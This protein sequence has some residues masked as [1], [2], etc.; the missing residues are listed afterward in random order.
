MTEVLRSIGKVKTIPKTVSEEA[1][2]AD[3]ERYRRLA[4]ELGAS[5]AAIVP[6]DWV[7][8]DER[9]RL[10]CLIPRCPRVGETPNCPPNSPEPD[11][12]RKAFSHYRWA[13]AVK[14][15]V[16]SLADY[17]VK[18]GASGEQRRKAFSFHLR[19][20]EIVCQLE[21]AAYRDG[22]YLALGLG[23]GSCKDTLCRGVIC[24][25]LDSGR[26]R[27]PLRARPAMEAL[28]IDVLQLASRLGWEAYPICHEEPNPEAI[29]Y[30]I[31][32]G[33]VFIH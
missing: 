21:G 9:V 18:A 24:Q 15:E 33:I 22:Y 8:V 31:T 10:K 26:C 19:S 25:F 14:V 1:L 28:G 3:L 17:V 27:F 23:G 7:V 16:T 29:P 32:V 4:L 20:H 6:A 2:Q 13:V 5:D 12:V 30:G 11:L